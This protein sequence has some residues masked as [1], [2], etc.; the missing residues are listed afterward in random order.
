M[1][2]I[3]TSLLA[4][5]LF[6]SACGGSDPDSASSTAESDG[7]SDGE[8]IA[9]EATGSTVEPAP[10]DAV[11]ISVNG[12]AITVAE[13]DTQIES[14]V[15][16]AEAAGQT[17]RIDDELDPT[18]VLA[19][20]DQYIRFES[21][22]DQLE[23]DGV[24]ITEADRE[25]A[26]ETAAASFPNLPEDDPARV[27]ATTWIAGLAALEPTDAEVEA[28]VADNS[29]T[30]SEGLL[31]SSHILVESIEEAEAV[32]ARLDGGETFADLAAEVSIDPGSGANGGDLGCVDPAS[33]VPEF[34]ETGMAAEIGVVTDP[35]ESE[36][37]QHLI[38]T[39]EP[40]NEDLI[41]LAAAA[42]AAVTDELLR[43]SLE[44]ATV[45][46]APQF[47]TWDPETHTLTAPGA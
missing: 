31:C 38:L 15:A 29:D 39:R 35:V 45:E 41:P 4:A 16:A 1:K 30:L 34:A 40:T 27:I 3:L 18:F 42:F 26:V 5:L 12:E 9:P 33:F 22:L 2:L 37:G 28:Y 11:G 32:I 24:E 17:V 6:L 20:T 14:W 47:G 19:M 10:D 21:L 23:A 13:F 43:G 8:T 25:Q 36:F 44:A 7:T 46:V